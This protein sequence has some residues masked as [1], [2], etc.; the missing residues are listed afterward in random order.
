V[1]GSFLRGQRGTE[2]SPGL[3]DLPSG[4]VTLNQ[5]LWSLQ[6]LYFAAFLESKV[7]ISQSEAVALLSMA[8]PSWWLPYISLLVLNLSKHKEKKKK[9]Y[10]NARNLKTIYHSRFSGLSSD[11]T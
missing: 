8:K 9:T 10:Q 11:M 7:C 4:P 3:Y 6:V 5:L 2:A 1:G